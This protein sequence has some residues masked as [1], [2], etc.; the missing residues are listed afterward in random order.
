MGKKGKITFQLPGFM[1][2]ITHLILM[3]SAGY[4]PHLEDENIEMLRFGCLVHNVQ[5]V[6]CGLNLNLFA[7]TKALPLS[8]SIS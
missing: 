2:E 4:H 5:G 7:D 1:L 6:Y 8:I 3:L